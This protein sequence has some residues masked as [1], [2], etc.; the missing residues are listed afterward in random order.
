MS[1]GKSRAIT[2]V[3]VFGASG[4][5]GDAIARAVATR[6]RELARDVAVVACSRRGA[7]NAN[8]R[9][10]DVTWVKC[11]ATNYEQ[12]ARAIG[13][14]DVVVCAIGALPT[15]WTSREDVVRANAETNVTPGRAAIKAKCARLIIV[16]ASI[17]S[18]I[19]GLAGYAKGKAIVEAF[20]R[21]EF[22]STSAS[23]GERRAVVLKPAAVSGTRDVGGW[24]IP[25]WLAMDPARAVIMRAGIDGLIAHAPV[26][27]E[28]VARAAARAA[29]DDAY[30]GGGFTV[31]TNKALIEDFSS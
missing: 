22:A 21:D 18:F 3:V 10:K 16:G 27:L 4:Y 26:P 6:A 13:D 7:P 1:H 29:L 15:P 23:E 8:A 17:P 2:K 30:G 20:A 31:L 28:N 9:A 14:A 11:D 12:S 24:G 25:L 5:V 19:P